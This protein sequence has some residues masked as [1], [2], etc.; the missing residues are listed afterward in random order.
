MRATPKRRLLSLRRRDAPRSNLQAAILTGLVAAVFLVIVIV[1]VVHHERFHRNR[2]EEWTAL[3]WNPAWPALPIL[4]AG[5]R[6]RL[7]VARAIY[8]FAGTKPEILE[9]IPCYCGCRAQ[10]HRSNH[11]CYVKHRSADGNVTAW[12]D[13]GLVCPLGPDITG[14]VMLWS[15]HGTSL[16]AIRHNI[17]QEFGSRG[18]ATPTPEPPSHK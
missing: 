7:D 6:L 10:G 1:T 11:D 4:G 13:H 15:E 18:P 3:P 8:A 5:G 16:S 14:D 2:G 17:D 9:F 12:D